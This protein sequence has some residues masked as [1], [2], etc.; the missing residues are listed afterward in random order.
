MAHGNFFPA[1]LLAQVAR[2][3][4]LTEAACHGRARD[5]PIL[6]KINDLTAE[7]RWKIV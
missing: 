3:Y 1:A 2:I 6:G 7:E 4:K 5:C